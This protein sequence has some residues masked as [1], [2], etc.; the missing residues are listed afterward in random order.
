MPLYQSKSKSSTHKIVQIDVIE[1][2]QKYLLIDPLS[3]PIKANYALQLL[4]KGR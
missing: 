1:L 4:H 2:I 3:I